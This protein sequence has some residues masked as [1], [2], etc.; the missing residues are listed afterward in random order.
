MPEKMNLHIVSKD[1][2]KTSVLR[3][4][5]RIMYEGSASVKEQNNVQ[6]FLYKEKN[7]EQEDYE[8]RCK[9][10]TIDPWIEK[11]VTA[12]Q[13]LLFAKK[14][15][16]NLTTKLDVYKDD[17]DMRG[18]SA[19]VF[20]FNVA[21]DAQIDG[22]NWVEVS[23]T[24]VQVQ[25]D[26]NGAEI[27][28]TQA[29]DMAQNH[30]PYFEQVDGSMVLDGSFNDID[31]MLDWV[32]IYSP[33]LT[34]NEESGGMWGSKV[35]VTPQ[36][37][38]WT[39]YQWF[40]YEEIKGSGP[41]NP[42]FKV[43][44][45]GANPTGVVP[46]VPFFGIKYSNFAGWPVA[47]S[48]ID[49]IILIYNKDSDLDWFERLSSHPIPYTIGPVKP[50]KIVSGKG[51]HLMTQPEQPQAHAGYLETNGAGFE[52][53]RESIRDLRYRIFSI[54]LAQAKKDT[55]QVQSADSQKEDR[56]IFSTSLKSASW[57]YEQSE[58]F[59]WYIFY[60]WITPTERVN[61]S[62]MREVADVQYNRDFDDSAIEVEMIKA[63]SELVI[64]NQL[65]LETFLQMLV[66]GE[67]LAD[68]TDV[69]KLLQAIDDEKLKTEGLTGFNAPNNPVPE[70]MVP[71]PAS[72]TP[73]EN[74]NV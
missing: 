32:V 49:H 5:S 31:M 48:V 55:A 33:K 25:Y 36:W 70:D 8:F 67:L 64:K 1:Y 2:E 10:S 66:D 3:K 72:P 22:I 58:M 17:V 65:P 44:E 23:M 63:L 13:S 47:K 56:R 9:R 40:V 14:H 27:V 74:A 69:E 34:R 18:T 7:E 37:K 26:E 57:L 54:A 60:L 42:D 53:L 43:V 46:V 11:I 20:F 45:Q 30:R 50:S 15:T 6:E 61:I 19:E 35:I 68:D 39:R 38:I 41:N 62:Q 29:D 51:F 21:R 71:Q 16:R 59:C 52:S 24:P 28:R 73:P 4:K 12:R